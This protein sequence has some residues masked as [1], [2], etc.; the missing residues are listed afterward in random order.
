MESQV[1]AQGSKDEDKHL[2][3]SQQTWSPTSAGNSSHMIQTN[4][5]DA[6]AGTSKQ[7]D[8]SA[9]LRRLDQ[10]LSQVTRERD[11]LKKRSPLSRSLRS[12]VPAPNGSKTNGLAPDHRLF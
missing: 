6:F 11:A 9:K 8:E 3:A 7:R 2:A 1:Q 12:E 4:G 10:Q 5:D